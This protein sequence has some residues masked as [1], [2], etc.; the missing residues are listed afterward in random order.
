MQHNPATT[1]FSSEEGKAMHT[2]TCDECNVTRSRDLLTGWR[3]VVWMKSGAER[4][5]FCSLLCEEMWCGRRREHNGEAAP[6][7]ANT[8]TQHE[9]WQEVAR[10]FLR[11]PPPMR[12]DRA[13]QEKQDHG[14]R[15]SARIETEDEGRHRV[16]LHIPD[17]TALWQPEDHEASNWR[18]KDAGAESGDLVD[19]QIAGEL[20]EVDRKNAGVDEAFASVPA[21]PYQVERRA[22]RQQARGR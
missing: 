9:R 7:S 12:D 18:R 6:A 14:W 19:C 4:L 21:L 15:I 17:G 2:V 13:G 11:V 22:A 16:S 5:H 10:E 3:E 8:A 20:T 1:G